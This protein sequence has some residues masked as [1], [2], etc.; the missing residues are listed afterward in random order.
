[1]K[2]TSIK[3]HYLAACFFTAL[4]LLTTSCTSSSN[5]AQF[6]DQSTRFTS[7]NNVV[8]NKDGWTLIWNDEFNGKEIDRTKWQHEINCWGGGNQEQQCYVD[9]ARN[10][11]VENGF[12]TIRAIRERT[13]GPAV[14]E[15]W[16]N[17][18]QQKTSLPFSSARL[19]TKNLADWKY[20]R[21]DIRA[22]LP[23]GQG[24]W[25]AIWMLP[26]NYVYGGWAASG[27]IDIMEAVNLHTN[28]TDDSGNLHKENRVHGTLHF[29]K[30]WPN[31]VSSGVAYDFGDNTI[32]PADDF[33]T[34]SI[35]WEQGEIRWYVDNLHYATQTED[36]WWTHYQDKD[37]KWV[38]GPSDAPFNQPFHL[39]LNLAM[40]GGWAGT[41]NDT[42]IDPA[43][44]YADMLIDYVRVYQCDADKNSGKGCASHLNESA[45]KNQGVE[46]PSL[47]FKKLNLNANILSIM[48]GH[49]LNSSFNLNGWDDSN[50]DTR[51]ASNDGLDITIV[52]AGNAYIEALGGEIN[53]STFKHGELTFDLM[54]E[55][56]NADGIIVKM[57][58]GWPNVA[59]LNIDKKDLPQAKQWKNYRFKIDD[60]IT[61]S[62]AFNITAVVN[63]VVFEPL[64]GKQVHFKVKNIQFTK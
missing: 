25:P 23:Q 54:T 38:S 48:D 37:K 46:E 62:A 21:F 27:E 47:T 22:K 35:E 5:S 63:P 57:D 33:H 26:T 41:T 13:S 32:N 55:E 15:D 7:D 49:T 2:I 43:L 64:N 42:G 11:F 50:N 31:N 16:D 19:R 14:P 36:G 59:A 4:P 44:N 28:Y 24:T 51:T 17:Y 3:P 9:K 30:N 6:I 8:K 52:G 20:G 61:A 18:G 10:A 40:G 12:L 45:T 60:F 58:S 29:G 1:M 39:L 34:Y 53:M 56:I